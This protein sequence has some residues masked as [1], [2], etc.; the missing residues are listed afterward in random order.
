MKT[1]T[2]NDLKKVEEKIDKLSDKIDKIT[3]I[4][5]QLAISQVETK[6]ELKGEIRILNETVKGINTRLDSQDKA[7][8][9]IPDLAEKVGELKNWKQIAIIVFTATVT[10]IAWILRDGKI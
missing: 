10:S 6:N 7:I 1:V 2:E 5:N 3:E 9:K 8:Q 4:I